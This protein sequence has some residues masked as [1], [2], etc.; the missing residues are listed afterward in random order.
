MGMQECVT[1]PWSRCVGHLMHGIVVVCVDDKHSDHTEAEALVP[2]TNVE[3]RVEHG[4]RWWNAHTDRQKA[5]MLADFTSS[6]LMAGQTAVMTQ[7]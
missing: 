5:Q 3:H 6:N 1:Q 4:N 2:L 7:F